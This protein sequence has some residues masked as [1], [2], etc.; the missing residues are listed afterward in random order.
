MPHPSLYLVFE[1]H[2][3]VGVAEKFGKLMWAPLGLLP[4]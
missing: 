2:L 4:I 1:Y 3:I